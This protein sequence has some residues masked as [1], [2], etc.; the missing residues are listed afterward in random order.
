MWGSGH[1]ASIQWGGGTRGG[2]AAGTKRLLWLWAGACMDHG[3][4][5]S[6]DAFFA[7]KQKIAVKTTLLRYRKG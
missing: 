7:K 5:G 3:A 1:G 2:L 4:V 6:F